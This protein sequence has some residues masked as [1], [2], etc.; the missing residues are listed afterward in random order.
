VVLGSGLRVKRG[1][2][3]MTSTSTGQDIVY[4]FASSTINIFIGAYPL[5]LSWFGVLVGIC[6]GLVLSG[7]V[8]YS[9]VY[10]FGLGRK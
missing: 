1:T 9:V 5:F 3:D 8:Y 7:A 4:A 2:F 6:F 10:A